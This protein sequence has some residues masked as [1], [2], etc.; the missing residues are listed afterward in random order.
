MNRYTTFFKHSITI[1][2]SSLEGTDIEENELV[3]P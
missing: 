1:A 3:D 2:D